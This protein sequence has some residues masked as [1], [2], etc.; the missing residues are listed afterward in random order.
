MTLC[1]LDLDFRTTGS[2]YFHPFG[3]ISHSCNESDCLRLFELV[4]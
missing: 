2:F 4:M 1:I 3:T